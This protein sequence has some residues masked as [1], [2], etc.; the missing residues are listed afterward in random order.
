MNANCK[1]IKQQTPFTLHSI[2]ICCYA[3]AG[4][5]NDFLALSFSF[6]AIRLM[7]IRFDMARI[8]SFAHSIFFFQSANL[9]LF[10]W[11]SAQNLTSIIW[12][13]FHSLRSKQTVYRS[14]GMSANLIATLQLFDFSGRKKKPDG[15][16]T[17][18]AMAR[19][20]R[21]DFCSTMYA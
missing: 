19:S 17:E 21:K 13:L 18:M 11:S 5:L 10:G 14:R 20:K 15:I 3:Y 9:L 7:K 1:S 16:R 6:F 4:Y 8:A 12:S 2:F